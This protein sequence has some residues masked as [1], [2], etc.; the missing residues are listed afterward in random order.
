MRFQ[1]PLV[2]G[3]LIQRYKRFLA[4]VELATGEIVTAH[5]ANPGAMLGLKEPGIPVWLSPAGNPKRKLQWNLQ[6]I[7]VDFGRG[8]GLV[9]INTGHPNKIAEEAIA[10]GLI[11]AL[12]GYD[13]IRREVKYGANSRID[14]LLEKEGEPDCYVEIKNVHLVREPGLAEFPDSVT[15]RGAKHL[16]ELANMVAEGA[17]AVMLYVIQIED[18]DAFTFARDIDPAYGTAFDAAHGAG[19]EAM[20]WRCAVSHDGIDLLAE[21]PLKQG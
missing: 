5:C 16:A 11:P 12:A 3:R 19:V 13:T 21:V 1:A 20:A 9:G 8:P 2:E 15:A 7:E 10:A 6:L 14:L 4:D 17:R 18:V